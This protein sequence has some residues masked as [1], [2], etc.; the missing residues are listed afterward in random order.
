MRCWRWL[1]GNAIPI[2]LALIILETEGFEVIF[3]TGVPPLQENAPPE[4]PT[5]GLC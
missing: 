3:S 4:D 2:A 5:V 1:F